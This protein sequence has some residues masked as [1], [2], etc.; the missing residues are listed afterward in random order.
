[1]LFFLLSL[2]ADFYLLQ[3]SNQLSKNEGEYLMKKSISLVLMALIVLLAVSPMQGYAG[4][5]TANGVMA[6]VSV[7]GKY[8]YV[9]TYSIEDYNYFKLRDI[10]YMLLGTDKQ[11]DVTWD[12]NKKAVNIIS[13]KVYNAVGDELMANSFWYDTI[14]A[15]PN[16]SMILLDGKEVRLTAYTINGYNYFKL[17][18]IAS[19]IDFFVGWDGRN[20][21][22]IIE[23]IFGYIPENSGDSYSYASNIDIDDT[24][25]DEVRNWAQISTIQQ[26]SYLDEGLAYA[27]VTDNLLK[28]VTPSRTLNIEMMYPLLDDVISDDEG[29]FYIVWGQEGTKSTDETIFISKYSQ[30]AY[31]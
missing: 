30:R 29:N 9:E 2:K 22:V 10:A 4:S 27:Y 20:N 8:Y 13:G 12:D 1:M 16:T 7:D 18:D 31:I 5:V 26:F 24:Q 11:F 6:R 17:R 23:S 25:V 21:T 19:I 3:Y 14:T 28:I 15:E